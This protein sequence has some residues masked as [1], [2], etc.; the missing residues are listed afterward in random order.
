LAYSIGDYNFLYLTIMSLLSYIDFE[1]TYMIKTVSVVFDFVLA[2]AAALLVYDHSDKNKLRKAVF[3]YCIVLSLPTVFINSAVWGQCDAMYTSFVLLCL[4]FLRREKYGKALIMYGLA[5]SLKL[6]SVFFLPFLLFFYYKEKKFSILNFLY[7]PLVLVATAL[8]AVAVG[9]PLVDVFKIYINQTGGYTEATLCYPNIFTWFK[10]PDE[11]FSFDYFLV[12]LGIFACLVVLLL[13]FFY[14]EKKPSKDLSFTHYMIFA[15]WCGYACV[16]LLP[17]MHE[18]YGFAAEILF[19]VL[20]L[21]DNKYIWAAVS[22]VAVG[23]FA[24][25]PFL[26]YLFE[27]QLWL[28]IF[29]ALFFIVFTFTVLRKSFSTEEDCCSITDH[30]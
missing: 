30:P 11:S 9:R 15:A 20:A 5:F 3:S 1:P 7:V 23:F 21:M 6:Q 25:F 18:R 17:R 12:Y 8:P 19:V 22:A 26:F 28:S 27:N 4:L 13:A 2:V 10:R 29:N 16:M 24:Y 14:C